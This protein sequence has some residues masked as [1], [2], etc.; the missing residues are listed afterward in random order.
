MNTL[1]GVGLGYKRSMADNFLAL[2][3]EISPI[4]FIEAS[5]ENWLKIGGTAR[6]KF[7][8]I[9]ER[10]P[11]AC[12]GLSLSLGGQDAL[13]IDFVRQIKEF[14]RQYHINFF[15]EHLS[16]CSHHGH[17]YDLLPL[18]FTEESV[19]H[20]AARIRIVQDILEQ[21]ISI[22]NISYYAHSLLAEMD[23]VD[24]LNAVAREADCGIHLDVNNV[25]VNAVNHG[26]VKSRDYIDRV[27]LT[28]VNYMHIAGHDGEHETLLIDTHGQAVCDAVWDLFAY[29][30]QR[31]PSSVPVL[32]ERDSNFPPFA[33]LEAEVKHIAA[34][35][36]QTKEAS[37]V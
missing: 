12:H 26:I 31:I 5:P 34:I 19:R 33:E 35:Q 17:I 27:D 8:A 3:Y 24:F 10:F 32:L 20:T 11:I 16:Y 36:K 18:P 9:A 22:E 1:Q 30:C 4:Q 23:E 28:R 15:S 2:D 13:Q 14:M 6:K 7:D 29:T 25:Y 21:Q 37:Y